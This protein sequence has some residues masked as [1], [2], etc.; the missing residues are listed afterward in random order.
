MKRGKLKASKR[1]TKRCKSKSK[2]VGSDKLT[3]GEPVSIV[4]DIKKSIPISNGS[5]LKG[6]SGVSGAENPSSSDV[7]YTGD[8]DFTLESY[9]SAVY[10]QQH[11]AAC[12]FLVQFLRGFESFTLSRVM[13]ESEQ[14]FSNRKRI[15]ITR[16]AAATT[17]LFASSQWQL[18]DKLYDVFVSY[19]DTLCKIY[20]VSFFASPG[21]VMDLVNSSQFSDPQ[22]KFRRF[23]LFFSLNSPPELHQALKVNKQLAAPVVLSMVSSQCV[24]K[25][26]QEANRSKLL[27]LFPEIL[28]GVRPWSSLYNALSVLWMNC[29]YAVDDRRHLVKSGINQIIASEFSGYAQ[30]Q[31]TQRI[32]VEGEKPKLGLMLEVC[33]E[34]HAMYRC[35]G[36]MLQSLRTYFDVTLFSAQAATDETVRKIA[37]NFI[38]V[39]EQADAMQKLAQQIKKCKFDL[40]YYPSLGMAKWSIIMANLRLAPVQCFSLGHPA[41]SCSEN[42]DFVIT[43]KDSIADPLCYTEKLVV[44]SGY[45][46][47]SAHPSPIRR[48]RSERVADQPVKVAIVSKHMKIN[49]LMIALCKELNTRCK[50]ELEF[51]FFPSTHGYML[52]YIE[53][54]IRAE[55]P[56]SEVFPYLEYQDYMSLISDCD[57]RLGTFPFAG[58]NTTVDCITL[59]IPFLT[60]DGPEIFNH[61]DTAT[62]E[63]FCP[64]MKDDFVAND[65]DSLI[66]KAVKLIDDDSYRCQLSGQLLDI[67]V[68]KA[69][70]TRTTSGES[71]AFGEGVNGHSILWA[72]R[73]AEKIKA[74]KQQVI[75][76]GDIE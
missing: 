54:S 19:H 50:S 70:Y 55:L 7:R 48:I 38:E 43:E 42:M 69:I 37:D 41:T 11:L 20:E 62:V 29:S 33:R 16:L 28:E 15:W 46:P 71:P 65:I 36:P 52:E 68:D 51:H 74:S 75:E 4:N 59:G 67:D 60:L 58:A 8:E 2:L 72:Y 30:L 57:L 26:E 61:T 17:A 18:D 44:A 40:I 25:E 9:E 5:Q 63:R 31:T 23:L 27:Q 6:H 45:P 3:L 53:Q 22:D 24:L 32:L 13:M 47:F 56:N 49:V 14:N 34:D 73:N 1:K 66:S 12:K 21:Y 35:Y 64:E 10:S 76:I 39:T